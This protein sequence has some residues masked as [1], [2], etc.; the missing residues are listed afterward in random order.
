MNK[1]QALF[2]ETRA[3]FL[4]VT[5]IPVLLGT[6]MAL[7]TGV[8][9]NW[10]I[11]LAIMFGFVF[12]HLG[13]NIINDYFD[14]I[15]GTDRIN[16]EFVFPF[17]GGS[18]LIQM[19]FLKPK[20]VL[21]ESVI[22]F[23]L[24]SIFLLYIFY[25]KGFYILFLLFISLI[26]GIFYT[27][28][29]FKWAHRGLGEFF[30]FLGFGPI[31]VTGAYYALSGNLNVQIFL[32]SI[33]IGLLASS[34]ID[35]NEF[36]DYNA[37]KVTGKRNIIVRIGKEKGVIFYMIT[38]ILSYFII[39][40]LSILNIMPFWSIISIFGFLFYLKAILILN[41]NYNNSLNLVAACKLTIFSHLVTGL[42]L[43]IVIF[44]SK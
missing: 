18:R 32:V 19:D 4:T 43:I 16:K 40:L 29:P 24:G 7:K 44:M 22:F 13:T 9:F 39:I 20:E 3:P 41:K 25:L 21:L 6:A 31:M 5:I 2:L 26:A 10:Q 23:I 34:I 35:I 30:I 36:P 27:A 37:D 38:G 8:P 14:D 33:P 12:L 28:P 15:N 42:I 1:L 11:F 17:T